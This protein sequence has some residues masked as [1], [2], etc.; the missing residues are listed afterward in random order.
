MFGSITFEAINSI[1]AKYWANLGFLSLI[2][3]IVNINFSNN[4]VHVKPGNVI[5][6]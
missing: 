5:C 1:S 2:V 3:C 4:S 6:L